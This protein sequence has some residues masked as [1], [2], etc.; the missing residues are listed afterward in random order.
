MKTN[1]I[2]VVAITCLLVGCS[3]SKGPDDVVKRYYSSTLKGDFDAFLSSLS[4]EATQQCLADL[5]DE[6]KARESF[7]KLPDKVRKLAK[8]VRVTKVEKN[9]RSAMV[10]VAE[11]KDM[12]ENGQVFSLTQTEGQ[13]LITEIQMLVTFYKN[14]SRRD[15]EKPQNKTSEHISEGRERP[16]ENAQR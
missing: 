1:L 7:S 10:W 2:I 14:G 12:P 15:W 4:P 11:G 16:S 9:G 6:E 13:W 8:D 3:G 5:G